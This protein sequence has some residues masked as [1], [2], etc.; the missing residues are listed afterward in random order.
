MKEIQVKNKQSNP[1]ARIDKI[2]IAEDG[3]GNLKIYSS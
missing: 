2:C 3:E 1:V